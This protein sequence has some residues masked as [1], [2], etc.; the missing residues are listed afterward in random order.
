MNRRTVFKNLAMATAAAW[1]L[2]SCISDPKKVSIALNRLDISGDEESLLADLA[3]VII[4][5]GDANSEDPAIA[6]P[7]A[8]DVGAHLFALVMV[9]DCLSKEERD[10]YLAGMRNF[11]NAVKSLTGKS[12]VKASPDERLAILKE[13]EEKLSSLDENVQ[14]FYSRTRRYI[15]QGY[16]ASEHFMTKIKPYELVPGPNYEGCV[17]ISP[18]AKTI[19]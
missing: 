11:D 3:D 12:F 14:V 8:R 16:T 13:T 4:P 19:S 2:P 6:G 1:M 17:S 15:I 10:K 18:D 7:G 5:R 9:D